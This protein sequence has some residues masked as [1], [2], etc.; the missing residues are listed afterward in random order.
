MSRL[1]ARFARLRGLFVA[2]RR[3]VELNEEIAGHLDLLAADY[4]RAGL[5]PGDARAAARRAFGGV[6]QVRETYREQRGLPF[7]DGF[8][9]DVR[10]ALRALRHHRTFSTIATLTLGLGIGATVAMFTVL[11]Q[12][13]LRQIPYPNPDRLVRLQSPV[14][15]VRSD[16]VWNLS[17]AQSFY[18]RREAATL[19]SVGIYVITSGT[20]GAV[21]DETGSTAERALNGLVSSEV[22]GLLGVRPVL[23]R[24]FTE[25]DGRYNQRT[26][27]PPAV[28][29]SYDVWQRRFGGRSEVIGQSLLFED[30]E[31]PVVGVLGPDVELPETAF[32]ST[33]RS[34]TGCRWDSTPARRL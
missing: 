26:E 33:G 30:R 9:R 13:V 1:R 14:P 16:A 25:E 4:E 2:R 23:G 24:L 5:S 15:G 31:F 29:L 6:A 27:S 32:V 19:E 3:D 18:F 10:V 34:A 28:I 7:V 20:L 8:A 22:F 11:D 17:T 21:S 12:V